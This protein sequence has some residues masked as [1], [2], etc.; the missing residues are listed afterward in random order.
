M[1]SLGRD[2]VPTRMGKIPYT[3]KVDVLIYSYGRCESNMVLF[4][5]YVVF[6]DTGRRHIAVILMPLSTIGSYRGLL[7]QFLVP[8]NL[9]RTSVR[10]RRVWKEQTRSRSKDS[11]HVFTFKLSLQCLI[12][13]IPSHLQSP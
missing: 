5:F 11:I 3:L 8:R 6:A 9:R 12:A 2:G 1:C 4:G 10:N 13:T 7:R